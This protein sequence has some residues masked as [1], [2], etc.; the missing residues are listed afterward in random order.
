MKGHDEIRAAAAILRDRPIP[1]KFSWL[2][3]RQSISRAGTVDVVVT[4]GFTG[5]IALKMLEGTAQSD[6]LLHARRPSTP[7]RSRSWAICSRAAP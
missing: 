3:R 4:D 5:N 6:H 1:G 7:R 2:C